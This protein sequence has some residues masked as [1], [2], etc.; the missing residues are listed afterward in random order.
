MKIY[1]SY[2]LD[3]MEDVVNVNERLN[4]QVHQKDERIALLQAK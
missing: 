1:F 4:Q 3:D 2:R